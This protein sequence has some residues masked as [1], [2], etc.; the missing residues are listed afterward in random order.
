M[1]SV[2]SDASVRETSRRSTMLPRMEATR[3]NSQWGIPK[4]ATG[5]ALAV[6][7]LVTIIG[8]PVGHIKFGPTVLYMIG[9]L[10]RERRQIGIPRP[11]GL[12]AVAIKTGLLGIGAR[13][14]GIPFRF[15]DNRRIV[16]LYWNQLDRQEDKVN[17]E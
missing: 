12:V 14:G 6:L 9:N 8:E 10:P 7:C 13:L 3:M 16:A 11:L 1:S 5:T 17:C 15:A 2:S 4:I